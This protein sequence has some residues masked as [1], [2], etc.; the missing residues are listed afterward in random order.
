[1]N[2]SSYISRDCSCN[3][4]YQLRKLVSEECYAC[5]LFAMLLF[6]ETGNWNSAAL[7]CCLSVMKDILFE[8]LVKYI[9]IYYK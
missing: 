3:L 5:L 6:D 7:L 2:E 1:M 4:F 9:L 8:A